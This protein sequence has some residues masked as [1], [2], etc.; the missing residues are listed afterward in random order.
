[1]TQ[2][3]KLG[4]RIAQVRESKKISAYELSLRIHRADNYM[5]YIETGRTNFRID[6]LFAICDA[7]EISPKE[8]FD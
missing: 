1:M 4:I 2:R 8:L 5:Y 6:N 3:E 7:L